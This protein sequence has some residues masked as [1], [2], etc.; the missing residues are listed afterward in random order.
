VQATL[1]GCSFAGSQALPVCLSG[2]KQ[3]VQADKYAAV[4]KRPQTKYLLEESDCTKVVL[5]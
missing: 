4:A 1:P 3:Y 5:A 2:K